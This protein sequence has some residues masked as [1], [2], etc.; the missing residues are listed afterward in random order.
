MKNFKE[1]T[2]TKSYHS[3]PPRAIGGTFFSRRGPPGP[4]VEVPGHWRCWRR[5]RG[6]WPQLRRRWWCRRAL[7]RWW[8]WRNLLLW[9]R[10]PRFLRSP[11]WL[12]AL[13]RRWWSSALPL[14]LRR[15]LAFGGRLPNEGAVAAL[16]PPGLGPLCLATPRG[17]R[18][19]HLVI[20]PGRGGTHIVHV[21]VLRH[22]H[23]I[24]SLPGGG[25]TSG[26]WPPGTL[27]GALLAVG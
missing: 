7:R 23:L 14:R 20:P 22:Q 17:G 4:L 15:L 5:G 6:L 27:A 13:R 16:E 18:P 12:L 2:Y 11:L 26:T 9:R 21:A 25:R 19:L 1:T 10:S 24:F 3:Q 8:R